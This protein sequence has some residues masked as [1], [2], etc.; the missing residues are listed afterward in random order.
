MLSVLVLSIC[1]FLLF[2]WMKNL[3]ARNIVYSL[4]DETSISQTGSNLVEINMK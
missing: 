3:K 4:K 1:I 2:T